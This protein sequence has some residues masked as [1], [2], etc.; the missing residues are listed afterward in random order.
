VRGYS[1]RGLH[2]QTV[3]VLARRIL[4]GEIAEGETIDVRTLEAEYGVSLTVVREAFRV[5]AAKGLVDA[6]QKRGTFV[7]P[8][9]SWHLLDPDVIQWQFGGSA[10]H[11]LLDNLA[12]LRGII[13]PAAARLAAERREKPDL[14]ALDEAL[15]EMDAADDPTAAV[16]ADLKF[17][18]ALLA[19][20]H[21]ELL[22]RMEVVLA[23]GLAER[24][25]IVHAIDHTDKPTP[26][27][28][29]VADAIEAGDPDAA[30][31]AM[32]KLLEKAA[33]DVN[34]ARRRRKRAG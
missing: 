29:A 3:E 26:A 21:N 10:D 22:S 33:R 13:E 2:G 28:A 23:A 12:E 25:R 32:R 34:R 19:A 15:K 17:H 14:E 9:E 16:D 20:T 6:R 30:E 18:R 5:L 11:A 24:D 27:H 1:G 31:L 8:R 7:R 4:S